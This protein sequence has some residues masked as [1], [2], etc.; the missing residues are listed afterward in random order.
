MGHCERERDRIMR[1]SGDC[2]GNLM[3][4]HVASSPLGL[5]LGG[6]GPRALRPSGSPEPATATPSRWSLLS[7]GVPLCKNTPKRPVS[8]LHVVNIPREDCTAGAA[9]TAVIA[10][11][12]PRCPCLALLLLLRTDAGVCV[13]VC[14]PGD[15]WYVQVLNFRIV[16]V[17]HTTVAFW[18]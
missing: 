2:P 14:P 1:A 9:S 3:S 7:A 8:F 6:G 11:S 13:Y 17:V 5:K 4:A 15:G 10:S 18:L 12:V 16:R